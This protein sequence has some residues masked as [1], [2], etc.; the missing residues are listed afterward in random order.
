[1]QSYKAYAFGYKNV[2]TNFTFDKRR[3]CYIDFSFPDE[4]SKIYNTIGTVVM[5]DMLDDTTGKYDETREG[6]I[7]KLNWQDHTITDY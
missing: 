2:T 6:Y 7:A 4:D 1:L 5:Y 3:L